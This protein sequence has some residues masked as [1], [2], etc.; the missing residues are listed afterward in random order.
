MTAE[1]KFERSLAIYVINVILEKRNWEYEYKNKEVYFILGN[2]EISTEGMTNK[3]LDE[4]LTQ[5]INW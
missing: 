4:L 3:E 1:D 5:I 2:E